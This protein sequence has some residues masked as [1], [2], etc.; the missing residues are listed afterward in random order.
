MYGRRYQRKRGFRRT[1]VLLLTLVM[2][3]SVCFPGLRASAEGENADVTVQVGNTAERLVSGEIGNVDVVQKNSGLVFEQSDGKIIVDATNAVPGTYTV[4]F[5]PENGIVQSFTVLV[6]SAVEPENNTEQEL[7]NH[8]LVDEDTE[9]GKTS[10]EDTEDGRTSDEDT[11]NGKTSDEG[12][13]DGKAPDEGTEDGKTI[14]EGTEDGNP[15]AGDDDK[16]EEIAVLES[17]SV[18]AFPGIDTYTTRTATFKP[19]ISHATVAYVHYDSNTVDVSSLNFT[20]VSGQ[21][22]SSYNDNRDNYWV[23]FVKPED[24]Y[25]LTGLG[26]SGNGDMYLTSGTNFGN[27]AGYPSIAELAAKAKEQ[28]YVAMFGYSRSRNSTLDSADFTVNC[29]SP[30]ITVTAISSKT[31]NVK[32]N[33]NLTFTV[34]ITPGHT[35]SGKDKVE[36]V[37][38]KTITVNGQEVSYSD[39][40]DNRDGTYTVT[41]DYT[42]TAD[43]CANGSVTLAVT[44]SVEY[45]GTLTLSDTSGETGSVN[46]NATITKSATTTCQI[47]PKNQVTYTHEYDVPDGVTITEYPESIIGNPVDSKDYY[48]GETVTVDTTY[49]NMAEIVDTV[50]GGKWTFDGWYLGDQKVTTATMDADG[51]TFTGVWKFEKT[52]CTVTVKKNVTGNMGDYEKEFSFTAYVNDKEFDTFSLKNGDSYTLENV[53]LGAKLVINE[54]NADGYTVSVDGKSI[55]DAASNGNAEYTVTSVTEGLEITF[56]NNKT[57]TIDTG[58]FT[59]T[60]PY[61]ILFSVAAVGAAVL[62]T[63]KRRYQV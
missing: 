24:N 42:A 59:D 18:L 12:T 32:P 37:N 22:N 2:L 27:I 25:L 36:G 11:E 39:V 53:P 38:I 4:V 9:D 41:V 10:N 28:G 46:T 23:F 34:T 6:T 48:S 44:A 63:K 14:D 29:E 5:G 58:V 30:D 31:E 20:N 49:P 50:N 13:K 3:A 8:A 60:A 56:T 17:V 21:F 61:I 40:K 26:A 52:L 19:T 7:E 54:T 43:D 55:K 33:D 35:S 45:S 47:A 1:L 15:S 62:L 16:Q 57:A 51:L